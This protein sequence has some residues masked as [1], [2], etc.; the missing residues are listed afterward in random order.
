[1]VRAGA[2]CNIPAMASPDRSK[3]HVT[4]DDNEMNSFLTIVK[5]LGT[6]AMIYT[7]IRSVSGHKSCTTGTLERFT[8]SRK[9]WNGILNASRVQRR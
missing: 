7:I 2:H 1:M 4:V 8:A 3:K 6:L 9:Y 5:L